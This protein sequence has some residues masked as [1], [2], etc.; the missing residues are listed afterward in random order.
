MSPRGAAGVNLFVG[1]EADCTVSERLFGGDLDVEF[2]GGDVEVFEEGGTEPA[3]HVVF[4][5]NIPVAAAVGTVP[6]EAGGVTWK[7][8]WREDELEAVFCV[9][10]VG[11]EDIEDGVGTAD[12]GFAKQADAGVVEDPGATRLVRGDD[13]KRVHNWRRTFVLRLSRGTEGLGVGGRL[14]DTAQDVV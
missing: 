4:R 11:G 3:F 10:D 5:P 13:K 6:N 12:E 9:R 8:L 14:N 2:F 1:E 7:R